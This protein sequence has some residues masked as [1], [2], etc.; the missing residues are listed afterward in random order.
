M[1]QT[2]IRISTS[3][4]DENGR[5]KLPAAIDIM[6]D[7]SQ[8]W[9]ES[10]PALRQFFADTG[11]AQMLIFRQT[12]IHRLPAYGEHLT[13]R[14]SIYACQPYYGYRNTMM[15]DE[16]ETC[17]LSSWSIGAFVRLSTGR[18]ARLPQQVINSVTMDPKAPMD[19]LD[20]KIRLPK[21]G[22]L[23]HPP[24]EV[25]RNDIDFNRHMNNARYVQLA[26][27]YLPEG[28]QPSRLR[29][30]YKKPAVRGTLLHPETLQQPDGLYGVRLCG[31]DG[32]LYTTMEFSCPPFLLSN[33][34]APA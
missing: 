17:C 2:E 19:Y 24:T 29:I 9:L 26:C 5:L 3:H 14:T 22:W 34:A 6:Q 20:K 15:Y 16:E 7:C 10:E 25:K 18:M 21:D 8:H 1:Y 32:Q 12:D 13:L 28:Y 23:P 30:E 27:E 4:T 31:N 33:G 11:T